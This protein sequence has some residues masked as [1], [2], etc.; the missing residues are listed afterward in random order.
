MTAGSKASK[1][2]LNPRF[3]DSRILADCDIIF[4]PSQ[5]V[6]KTREEKNAH[7]YRL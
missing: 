6:A 4:I 3:D 7:S 2:L 1:D 5:K